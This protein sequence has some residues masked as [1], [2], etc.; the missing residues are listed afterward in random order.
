MSRLRTYFLTGFIVLAPI[1]ITA[2]IALGFIEWVDGLIKPLIPSVYNPDTYLPFPVPGIGLIL[3]LIGITLIG[4]LTANFVGKAILRFGEHL[5]S[6]M[7]LVRN[8]Y[9]A[10]KQIL[11]TVLSEKT[12]SFQQAALIEY[13]RPGMW[14]LCFVSTE[15]RGEVQQVTGGPEGSLAVF[16]PTTPNP[17]S[18]FLLFVPHE[19]VH[20]LNM[21]VED[22]AKL[23][24]SGGLVSPE[25]METTRAIEALADLS[26]KPRS[27]ADAA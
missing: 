10:L 26:D 23:I 14:A 8:I 22:A 25:E 5:V 21:S 24:I 17:T 13:P 7:P 9:K 18:G 12:N 2:W 4:F 19:D 15:A 1:A 27:D 20:I 3:A 16:V 11:E 6:R